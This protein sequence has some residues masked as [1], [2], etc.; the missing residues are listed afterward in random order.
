ME[1]RACRASLYQAPL[2][3]PSS[4][5]SDSHSVQSSPGEVT[6]CPVDNSQW[7]GHLSTC[8]R[9]SSHHS[10]P[11]WS[12]EDWLKCEFLIYRVWGWAANGSELDSSPGGT[13]DNKARTR[14]CGHWE[15][16][17]TLQDRSHPTFLCFVYFIWSTFSA[18]PPPLT[19]P[20][21]HCSSA[22]IAS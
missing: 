16:P 11:K 15:G 3:R 5:Q 12:L 13:N 6:H 21:I 9:D 4:R 8:A 10:H 19:L 17:P 1:G 22:L 20:H 7:L 18:F 14:L 2:E